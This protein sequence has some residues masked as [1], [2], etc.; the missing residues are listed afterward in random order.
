MFYYMENLFSIYYIVYILYILYSNL[1]TIF[2]VVFTEAF[3][4]TLFAMT[5]FKIL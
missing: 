5:N 3:T 2:T 4:K 1:F